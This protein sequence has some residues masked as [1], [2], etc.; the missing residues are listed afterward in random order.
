VTP[1]AVDRHAVALLRY[2]AMAT[3]SRETR[4]SHRRRAPARCD[5]STRSGPVRLE[6]VAVRRHRTDQLGYI[7]GQETPCCSCSS[8]N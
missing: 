5:R 4:Q 2:S 1:E 8:R 6:D 3:A 7:E